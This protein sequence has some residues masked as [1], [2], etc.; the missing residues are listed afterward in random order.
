LVVLLDNMRQ[1]FAL[2]ILTTQLDWIGPKLKLQGYA[3]DTSV[4]IPNFCIENVRGKLPVEPTLLGLGFDR[5]I[6]H[7]DL[8]DALVLI[9]GILGNAAATHRIQPGDTIAGVFVGEKWKEYITALNFEQTAAEVR[10]CRDNNMF[11]HVHNKE[12]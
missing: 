12:T 6:A 3:V 4:S 5:T 11:P 1:A 2:G 10:P 8:P 7:R 9:Q